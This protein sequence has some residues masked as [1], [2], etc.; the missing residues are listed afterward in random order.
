MWV[1]LANPVYAKCR[2]QCYGGPLQ[3]R[4]TAAKCPPLA[5][6]I[7]LQ[8]KANGGEWDATAS[9]V[10]FPVVEVS[11]VPNRPGVYDLLVGIWWI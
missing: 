1:K 2:L 7:A 10:E 3:L 8:R 6:A 5:A 9:S 11:W 4:A